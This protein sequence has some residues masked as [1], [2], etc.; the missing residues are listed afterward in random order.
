M[1][2]K[3]NKNQ[4]QTYKKRK[5]LGRFGTQVPFQSFSSLFHLQNRFHIRL[6]KINK[7]PK[8]IL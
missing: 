3:V 5:L 7:Q 8:G 4:E 2:I 6:T 1:T